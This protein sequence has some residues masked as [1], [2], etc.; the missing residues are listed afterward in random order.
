MFDA[1]LFD[2]DGTLLDS[3]E[4]ILVS[5]RHTLAHHGLPTRSDAD[6]LS[7]L[8]T[9]LDAQ[10]RRWGYGDR[11]AELTGTYIEHNLRMHDELVRPFPG[12]DDLVHELRAAGVPLALVT[13]KRRRG[14]EQGLRRLG[15]AGC[16]GAEIYGDEVARPKPAPDPVLDAVRG[17]GVEPS[18]RV[19]FVGDAIHDVESGQAAGIHTV[20]VSWGSGRREELEGADLVVDD[21]GALRRALLGVGA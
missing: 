12:T 17:L 18:T 10:F 11:L 14:G 7:G 4:L 6:I 13:S 21:V 8:G 1:V 5:Y 19:A 16:F 15:I 2:L 9:T 3:I 20:A